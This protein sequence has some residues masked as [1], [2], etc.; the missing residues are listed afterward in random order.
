[1]KECAANSQTISVPPKCFENQN[2]CYY[3]PF[4]VGAY[5]FTLKT[6]AVLHVSKHLKCTCFR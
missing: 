1:M 5:Y 2:A 6:Y 4:F 3:C